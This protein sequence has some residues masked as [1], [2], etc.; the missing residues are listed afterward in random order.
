MI[1]WRSHGVVAGFRA[2]GVRQVRHPGRR[3]EADD[4][5]RVV[6]RATP[7][8]YPLASSVIPSSNVTEGV[9]ASSVRRRALSAVMW[10]TSPRR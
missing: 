10:R 2:T 6:P 4:R 5:I 7:A 3:V 1:V 8:G 9:Q